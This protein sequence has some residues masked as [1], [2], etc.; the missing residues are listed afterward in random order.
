MD[1]ELSGWRECGGNI[2]GDPASQ[3]S[4]PGATGAVAGSTPGG[5]ALP[6]SQSQSGL[7]KAP[8]S[9]PYVFAAQFGN[10]GKSTTALLVTATGITLDSKGDVFCADTKENRVVEFTA[11]GDYADQFGNIGSPAADLVKSPTALAV[12]GSRNTDVIDIAGSGRVVKFSKAKKYVG[13]FGNTGTAA[14]GVLDSPTAI[15]CDGS[16]NIYVTDSTA[17][18]RVVKFNKK[19]AYATQFGNNGTT[20]TGLLSGPAGIAIDGSGDIYVA[21]SGN[22]RVVEFSNKCTYRCQFA[23]SGESTLKQPIAVAADN[24]GNVYIVD[25]GPTGRVQK[26][27][28]TGTLITQIGNT[29][30]TATGLLQNPGG[31]AV[32]ADGDVYVADTGNHRIV[33]FKR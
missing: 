20:A 3:G 32:G 27:G 12:D 29:G 22:N 28:A 19:G 8:A 2:S 24:T 16:G 18:G 26:F 11:A 31:I 15:A 4:T 1:R 14:T 7:L 30:T 10:S 23:G 9:A 21:D 17:G 6:G 5:P 25:G 13:D 33:K